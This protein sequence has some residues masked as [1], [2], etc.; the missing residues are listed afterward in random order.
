[1]E[2]VSTKELLDLGLA[3]QAD[4]N[5]GQAVSHW[6]AAAKRGSVD[7][8]YNIGLLYSKLAFATAD[9]DRQTAYLASAVSAFKPIAGPEFDLPKA[10]FSLGMIAEEL[11][12][13]SLNAPDL[14]QEQQLTAANEGFVKAAG[15][16]KQASAMPDSMVDGTPAEATLKLASFQMLGIG[17]YEKNEAAA[18]EMVE[19]AKRLC[20]KLFDNGPARPRAAG[21]APSKLTS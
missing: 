9:P 7:G 3:A 19:E 1:M 20:P 21:V 16:F 4:G 15:Y 11:A 8:F 5:F 13:R 6:Q 14:T 10:S 17:G 12:K 18:I 2:N